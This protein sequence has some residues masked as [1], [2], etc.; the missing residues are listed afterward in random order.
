MTSKSRR[1]DTPTSAVGSDD[2]SS[3][4]K[5]SMASSKKTVSVAAAAKKKSVKR[6]KNKKKAEVIDWNER[7]YSISMRPKEEGDEEFQESLEELR[8]EVNKREI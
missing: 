2:A 5:T 6:K 7:M 4:G 8:T 3:I 1:N